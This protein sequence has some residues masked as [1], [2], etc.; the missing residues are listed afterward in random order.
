MSTDDDATRILPAE[1]A[2]ALSASG[3]TEIGLPQEHG[4]D[5]APIRRS[6]CS[7]DF[8]LRRFTAEEFR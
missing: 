6:D 7:D 8:W 3:V 4:R 2:G 1:R 5:T